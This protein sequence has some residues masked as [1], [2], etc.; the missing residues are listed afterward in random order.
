MVVQFVEN[1]P[2]HKPEIENIDR[3]IKLVASR[4]GEIHFLL[5]KCIYRVT[6]KVFSQRD[7]LK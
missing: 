2:W 6:L 4:P 1:S 5:Y 7:L 3:G